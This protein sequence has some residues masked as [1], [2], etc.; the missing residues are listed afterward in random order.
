MSFKTFHNLTWCSGDSQEMLL[1]KRMLIPAHLPCSSHPR[2]GL[3]A[4]APPH[5]LP[6]THS[7]SYNWTFPCAVPSTG[8]TAHL[9]SLSSPP[10]LPKSASSLI[11][12]L[13][14]P[15]FQEDL[16]RRF[17]CTPMGQTYPSHSKWCF[18]VVSM[19]FHHSSTTGL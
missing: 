4:T 10:F 5:F 16:P 15:S 2:S 17:L 7:A 18:W 14:H 9:Q 12:G 11:I 6:V 8:S 3:Q 19:H 1:S 13:R